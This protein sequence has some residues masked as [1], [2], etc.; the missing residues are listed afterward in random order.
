MERCPFCGG[1]LLSCGCIYK[2]VKVESPSMFTGEELDAWQHVLEVKGRVPYIVYPNICC[3]CGKLWP[4][5]FSVPNEEWRHYIQISMRDKIL[6]RK[7]YDR[8]KKI[9]DAGGADKT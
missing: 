3:K 4:Y 2:Y 7:C 6:C 5:F 9:I 1:Q 8:I